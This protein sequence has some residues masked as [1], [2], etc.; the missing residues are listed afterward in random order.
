MR[1]K[2]QNSWQLLFK[3]WLQKHKNFEDHIELYIEHAESTKNAEWEKTSFAKEK[4][5][6]A[7]CIMNKIMTTHK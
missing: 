2:T 6:N 4:E 5:E 3:Q 1:T 7:V